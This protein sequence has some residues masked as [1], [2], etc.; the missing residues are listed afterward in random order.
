MDI[1]ERKI[2]FPYKIFCAF[3]PERCPFCDIPIRPGELYC[4]KCQRRLKFTDYRTYAKGGVECICTFP[5]TDEYKAT[6]KR[7][8][9]SGRKQ[10]AYSMARLMADT[11]RKKYADRNFDVITCVPMHKHSITER[12]YN[13]SALLAKKLS[14][15]LGIP[16]KPLLVKTKL[17]KP[18]H[19][20]KK[21]KERENNIKGAFRITNKSY[22]RRKRILL[23]D[24]IITTGN[25]LGE[26]A[27]TLY[28]GAP[29]DICCATFAISVVKNDLK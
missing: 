16:Y 6:V 27:R 9:F 8:K 7:F 19:S 24:D 22:L 13:Q 20:L 1:K 23:I 11:I 25:T 4:R 10:Y 12:G 2:T 26:C 15:M 18:Q 28:K 29:E 3:L 21:P 17:T 14:F 5:Y